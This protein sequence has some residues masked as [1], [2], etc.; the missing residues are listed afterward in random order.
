MRNAERGAGFLL[1]FLL[2][3]ASVW[4]YFPDETELPAWDVGLLTE[5]V[6]ATSDAETPEVFSELRYE[7][8]KTITIRSRTLS[9]SRSGFTPGFSRDEL[10]NLKIFGQLRDWRVQATVL[11]QSSDL[12]KQNR[13]DIKLWNDEWEFFLGEF[14]AK[15]S[16]NEFSLFHKQLDGFYARQHKGAWSQQFVLSIPQGESKRDTFFGNATQGPYRGSASPWVAGSERV[17]LDGVLLERGL[18]Y[19]VDY[20]LGQITF[21][22]LVPQTS[23]RIEVTYE[24]RGSVFAKNLFGYTAEFSPSDSLRLGATLV[25]HSDNT[26]G[27]ASVSSQN[28]V[29]QY[30]AGQDLRWE[31]LPGASLEEVLAVTYRDTNARD[32][33]SGIL[34][35]AGRSTLQ[36][37]G[38]AWRARAE[39][40]K[41]LSD[42]ESIGNTQRPPGT[43]AYGLGA[44]LFPTAAPQ[45]KAAYNY[46]NQPQSGLS[47]EEGIGQLASLWPL[48]EHWRF[49]TDLYRRSNLKTQSYDRDYQRYQ[50]RLRGAAE[51]A[52]IFVGSQAEILADQID[53]TQSYQAL[54]AVGG[55]TL[56]LGQNLSLQ[57]D[58][59][60]EWRDFRQASDRARAELRLRS[61]WNPD[62]HLSLAGWGQSMVESG[63]APVTVLNAAYRWQPLEAVRLEGHQ[64]LEELSESYGGQNQNVTRQ[65]GLLSAHA[66]LPLR[67]ALEYQL[68][69]RQTFLKQR[70][71]PAL[72]ERRLQQFDVK[73]PLGWARVSYRYR[74]SQLDEIDGNDPNLLRRKQKSNAQNHVYQTQ[75]QL[76]QQALEL[77]YENNL[78][79]S[80]TL[81]STSPD[82]YTSSLSTSQ[83]YQLA[84]RQ[85]LFQDGQ[86][87][88]VLEKQFADT[89]SPSSQVRSEVLH[90]RS[91]MTVRPLPPVILKGRGTFEQTLDP[92][93]ASP[94]TWTL[95]PR[96]ELQY[97][98]VAGLSLQGSY[99]YVRS[100][101]GSDVQSRV[102]D[103]A[104]QAEFRYQAIDFSFRIQAEYQ[105]SN[106]PQY[107]SWDLLGSLTASF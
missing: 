55:G 52:E 107:E 30:L 83:K 70:S 78:G 31:F 90:V 104:V 39:L 16:N 102:A 13:T 65:D 63:A 4:G 44:E 50:A 82:V 101:K 95:S 94:E 40:T 47:D 77:R 62:A 48:N 12:D 106:N 45:L 25:N 67:C 42:F 19:R 103:A 6:I 71:V 27:A 33:N 98:P 99:T 3:P 7:G 2:M 9:G 1:L 105:Q 73:L 49:E 36:A 96:V 17:Y 5:N 23:A 97:L 38:E 11:Q 100:V 15:F 46:Q 32:A 37:Q 59:R 79:D 53:P 41:V 69:P 54:G 57:S 51:N 8:Y 81:A 92:G 80:L 10:L 24:F 66:D 84:L 22:R 74:L 61:D 75:C 35:A 26:A 76:G 64:Q 29:A 56:K 86:L 58:G 21:L 20:E 87:E 18:D 91:E 60:L 28:P 68:Q 89:Q 88:S 85:S 14:L 34:S 43:L 72:D 93:G